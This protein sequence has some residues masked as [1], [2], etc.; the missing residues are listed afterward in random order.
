MSWHPAG[1]NNTTATTTTSQ[2][3]PPSSPSTTTAAAMDLSAMALPPSLN[4]APLYSDNTNM[5]SSFQFS[6]LSS[7]DDTFLT[8]TSTSFLPVDNGSPV[9]QSTAWDGGLADM[10]TIPPPLADGWPF[11]MMLLNDNIPSMDDTSPSTPDLLPFQAPEYNSESQ[12]EPDLTLENT[13]AKDELVGMGLY[14]QP[15]SIQS[16]GQGMLGKGLKLEETFTPST[17]QDKQ[18]EDDND[19]EDEDEDSNGNGNG[20]D[21]SNQ[22]CTIKQERQVSEPIKQPAKPPMNMLSQPFL[23]DN[24]DGSFD[25]HDVADS[26]L[27]FNLNALGN[28]NQP[29]VNYGYG[30]I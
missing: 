23:F 2:Y 28:L 12:S 3:F 18:A 24:E 13:D 1:N 10:S 25:Q 19:D 16:L 4:D 5:L 6:G 11:D 15:E 7:S 29:C 26:Q 14:N 30:W 8:P 20:N 9:E 22:D 21:D 17:D 27:L